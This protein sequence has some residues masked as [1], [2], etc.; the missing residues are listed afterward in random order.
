MAKVPSSMMTQHPDCASRYIAIQE[1]VEEAVFSLTP[2]PLGL[3]IEEAMVDFEGKL[4]PYHQTGQIVLGLLE[5]GIY[6]G[7][8][9][10]ITPRISNATEETVFKQLMAL[11]SV[12]EANYDVFE[13]SKVP[14]ITEVIHPMSKTPQ[15]MVAV[16]RR[17]AD[18]IALGEKEFGLMGD[19]NTVQLIPLVEEVPS[20]LSFADLFT[21][22][23]RICQE[24]RYRVDRI[25]Y[26]VGRSDSALVY[27]H[28]PSV[29]ANKIAIAEGH[30]I[31]EL[32]G[33]EALPILGG[34][35]LP[36]RGHVTEENV[37]NLLEDFR[38]ARTVTIQ[39]ALRYDH[40][41]EKTRLLV[42]FFRQKL[43]QARPLSY[44][45]E[46]R[47]YLINVIAI[48]FLQYL[49]TFSKIFL[50]IGRV[51][52]LI[53]KQ[54]DRLVRKGP[55]GYARATAD[56]QGLAELVTHDGLKDFL[57]MVRVDPYK[58]LPRAISF[59]GAL[60]SLGIPPEFIGTGRGL[61]ELRRIFGQN[62]V[63]EL[64]GY[65]PSLI[66]D[67]TFAARFVDLQNASHFFREEVIEELQE[68]VKITAETLQLKIGPTTE[69][70]SLYRTLM[71][72][73]QPFLSATLESNAERLPVV[74]D[75]FSF[76]T[77]CII[78][79][80]KIRGSLG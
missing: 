50:L 28:I 23:M 56:P 19:P 57:E 39:S 75:G 49:K 22:Y 79:M 24:E 54:R 64:L 78:K 4:T 71:R 66:S 26:M 29:L 18:V 48:F 38:G 36:F 13:V 47:K 76:V 2:Q 44:T 11:M 5:R 15:E 74:E 32:Y 52:D 55:S 59:T 45:P 35:A 10:N 37:V 31:G 68:D 17:I 42:N 72:S 25:R 77:E 16:R 14:A 58:E 70:D 63:Q 61:R 51:S 33:L 27:G 9:V 43:P 12:I 73:I 8:D 46:E 69:T 6:P 67:L 3:G 21:S 62:A 20:L 1:E 40:G 80:G 30:R 34:G 60:Y 41:Y 53:P 65:Y 7:V